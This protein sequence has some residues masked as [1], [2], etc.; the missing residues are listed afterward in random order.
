MSTDLP[1]TFHA[2]IGWRAG[3]INLETEIEFLDSYQ[4]MKKCG[5]C[6]RL[7][8]ATPGFIDMAVMR[9][10]DTVDYISFPENMPLANPLKSL[11]SRQAWRKTDAGV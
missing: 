3:V 9:G 5:C 6:L 7:R 10:P 2:T 1:T 11:L 4:D 8:E